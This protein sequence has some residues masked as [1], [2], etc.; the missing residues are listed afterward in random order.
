M[1]S[2]YAEADEP[3]LSDRRDK[4][5]LQF[6]PKLRFNPGNPAYKCVFEPLYAEL[7]DLKPNTIPSF[8]IRIQPLI[9]DSHLNDSFDFIADYRVSQSAPW[10]LKQPTLLF[11][12][13]RSKKSQT[14]PTSYIS[15][16]LGIRAR[17]PNHTCLY[18]DG[19]KVGE[20]VGSAAVAPSGIVRC[21]I[22]DGATVFSAEMKALLLALDFIESADDDRFIIF[23]DSL[24]SMQALQSRKLSDPLVLEFLER[25]DL[26]STE[27]NIV[28][29]WLPSHIGIEGNEKADLAARSALALP[30]SNIKLNCNKF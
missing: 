10:L 15:S 27:K 29:C 14:H 16:F 30:L 2:L 9:T 12:R 19:S 1:E 21:R 18:T 23:T 7:F 5:G 28:L 3:S 17:Y 26:M 11:D 24:S 20:C 6:A 25:L 13:N 22:P 8:G 4:L